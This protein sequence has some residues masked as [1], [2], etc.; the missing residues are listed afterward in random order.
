MAEY[1]NAPKAR[2]MQAIGSETALR[3]CDKILGQQ[4]A[5]D[6]FA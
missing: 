6:D 4:L 3:V 2:P 5:P 1:D